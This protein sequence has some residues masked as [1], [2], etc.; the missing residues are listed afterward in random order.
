MF[1]PLSS[2]YSHPGGWRAALHVCGQYETRQFGVESGVTHLLSV[3]GVKNRLFTLDGLAEDRHLVL[4]FDDTPDGADPDA[5][6]AG[7]VETVCRWVDTLPLNAK[8]IV[9]CLQGM[10][11]SAAI[12]LGIL[13]RYMPPLDAGAALHAI[14]PMA[15]PN[16]LMV[17]Q[18]DRALSLNGA[19]L[20][21]AARF[22]CRV[23]QTQ[24]A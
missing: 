13:A 18:W 5:P 14:R 11:R 20:A 21:A 15:N 3:R 16:R 7:H 22:P 23:W 24:A 1:E 6:T 9:H 19:L 8:L 2:G 4:V 12:G 17:S 10:H